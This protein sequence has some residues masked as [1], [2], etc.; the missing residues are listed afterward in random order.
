MIYS[1]A[2][3]L[4]EIVS[5]STLEPLPDNYD[6]FKA[7]KPLSINVIVQSVVDRSTKAVAT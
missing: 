7:I 6:C 2:V 4:G 5:I 3:A 1:K